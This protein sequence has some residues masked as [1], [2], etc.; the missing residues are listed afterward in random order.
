VVALSTLSTGGGDPDLR[1]AA[2]LIAT[3][4]KGLAG[5][6]SRQIPDSISV[7][8]DGKVATISASAPPA[9]PAE[10][11]LRHPLFGDR[12]HWYAAPGSPFLAPA[13]DAKSDAAMA[14]YAKKIDRWAAAALR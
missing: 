12:E 11:R 10:L 8:V 4:A 9:R 13:A 2:D 5:T 7:A 6:W 1:A 3:S 14:R